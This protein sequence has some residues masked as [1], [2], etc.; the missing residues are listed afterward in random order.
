MKI[1]TSYIIDGVKVIIFCA[2]NYF[3]IV[4]RSTWKGCRL[5]LIKKV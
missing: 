4:V 3:F 2:F 1:I 5:R